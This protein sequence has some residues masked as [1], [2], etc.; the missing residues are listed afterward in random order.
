MYIAEERVPVPTSA[1]IELPLPTYEKLQTIARRRRQPI[2]AVVDHWLAQEQDLLPALPISVEEELAALTHLSDE[3][4]WLVARS[5][6]MPM[7]SEQ[8]EQL[9]WKAQT[10]QGL[11]DVEARE[12]E[13][14]L[15][16]DQR[17]LIRRT[18]A[19]NLLKQRGHDI[20]SLFSQYRHE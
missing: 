13:E 20:S 10:T 9:T 2:V 14:L 18:E 4:L 5:T 8:L 11:T 6:L 3:L 12:Q 19:A 17:T 7:Q 16:L 1:T 15:A